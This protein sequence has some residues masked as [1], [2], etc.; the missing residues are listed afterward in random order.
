MTL[1]QDGNRVTGTYE[2]RGGVIEGTVTGSTLRFTW[3]Q[4]DRSGTGSFTLSADGNRFDGTWT[5][6]AGDPREGTWIGQ[7]AGGAAPPPAAA[8][9]AGQWNTNDGYQDVAMTLRQDG[10]RV[11]GTYEHRGGVIEGTV[12]GNTLSLTWRQ[13]DRSGTGSFTLSADGNRFDGTWTADAG[14]PREGTWIGQRIGGGQTEP[15]LGFF[16]GLWTVDDTYARYAMNLE[17][18]GRR[19]TG[20]YD[21]YGGTLEG[22]V[23]GRTLT[24]T[25]RQPDNNRSGTLR[26]TLAENGQTF[27]G[28]W[29]CPDSDPKEGP[30]TGRRVPLR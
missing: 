4:E 25:W 2:H 24:G 28:T 3:R 16:A 23:T 20:T 18:N 27:E 13:D 6:D 5:A 19:V 11:T 1:R 14:D 15:G 17:Q 12:T 8:S 9:F 26:L 10:N 29:N 21:R 30:W 22:T 7:R